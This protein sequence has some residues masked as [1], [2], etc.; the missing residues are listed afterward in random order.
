[1]IK[2]A[3][4]S[5]KTRQILNGFVIVSSILLC[6]FFSLTRLPGME[7]LGI[8]PNW[9]MMWVIAWSVKR[10]IFQAVVA[11]LTL[12]LIQDGIT[13][14]YPSHVVVLV[15]IAYITAQIQKQRYIKE[16][17]MSVVL[18]VFMM[19]L[20]SETLLAFQYVISGIR[21]LDEIW[22]DYQQIALSS[23]IL[24][25]LWTPVLYYPLN[26]WWENIKTLD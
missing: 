20:F 11:G 24:S 17:L 3:R 14:S 26:N 4:L 7:L 23:A 13:S 22:L 2:V 25:S 18:I 19:S 6:I 10:T 1:M 8:G 9:L 12:G 15:L 5:P 16:D 21:P